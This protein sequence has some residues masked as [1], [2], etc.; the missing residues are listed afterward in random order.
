MVRS[1]LSRLIARL[2]SVLVQVSV[3]LGVSGLRL[4]YRT[5]TNLEAPR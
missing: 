1:C 5:G 2:S 3:V 4:S